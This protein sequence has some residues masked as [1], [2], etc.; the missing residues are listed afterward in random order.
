VALSCTFLWLLTFVTGHQRLVHTIGLVTALAGIV[1][2]LIIA[3]A[4]APGTTSHFNN[5]TTA[6][7]IIW[8]IMAF[9]VIRAWIANL[10]LGVLLLR[11]RLADRALAWSLRLG[12]DISPNY[13]AGDA[14]PAV[15]E[16]RRPHPG[17][18]GGDRPGRRRDY[19]DHPGP[20]PGP[21]PSSR[22]RG[23]PAQ[24]EC[25]MTFH[26]HTTEQERKAG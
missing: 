3:G 12:V 1:E 26:T 7:S 6:H 4:A 25:G 20:G 15:G 2:L 13:L 19:R 11:Q 18:A 17:G 24:S 8:G 23:V 5:S 10:V 21:G 22:L 16:A 9:V 14:W